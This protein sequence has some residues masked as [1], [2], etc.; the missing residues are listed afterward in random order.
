MS[1]T[2]RRNHGH[3][4]LASPALPPASRRSLT[5]KAGPAP[6]GTGLHGGKTAGQSSPTASASTPLMSQFDRP[7]A[8]LKREMWLWCGSTLTCGSASAG[9]NTSAGTFARCRR[10]KAQAPGSGLAFAVLIR[11]APR[12]PLSAAGCL[13][14]R[15]FLLFCS[16]HAGSHLLHVSGNLA[17]RTPSVKDRSLLIHH[18]FMTLVQSCDNGIENDAVCSMSF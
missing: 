7:S 5:K 9:S 18:S 10:L 13:C 16:F 12:L 4:R 17:S 2:V 15:R 6:T 3:T 11:S 8:T 1:E 14:T